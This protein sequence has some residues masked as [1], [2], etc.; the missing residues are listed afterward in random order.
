MATAVDICN[1]ALARLGDAAGVVSIS[2][3]DA[4]VQAEY[5]S[6]FYPLALSEALD[7]HN[8]TFA[9]RR[10]VLIQVTPETTKYKYAFALPSDFIRLI[11]LT[12]IAG[13]TPA[14]E[15]WFTWAQQPT[16]QPQIT[17]YAIET[18]DTGLLV[19]YCDV[20]S[21][22][23]CYVAATTNTATFS[24]SFTQYLS[25]LLAHHLA[26]PIIKGDVGVTA[27]DKLYQ[28]ALKLKVIAVNKDGQNYKS[29]Y[30]PYPPLIQSRF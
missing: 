7:Q 10:D 28:T 21:V 5:C 18:L 1:M 15:P 9:T 30:S 2:P 14:A 22:E 16:N 25:V 24:P 13:V 8:W 27:A 19:L 23:L 29:Q 3:P 11:E 26:G 17:S 12:L 6:I 20:L 4:S